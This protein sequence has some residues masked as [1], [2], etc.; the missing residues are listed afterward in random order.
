MFEINDLRA[1]IRIADLKSVSAAAKSLGAP[2]SSVSRSM[3]RLEN[4]A[5]AALVERSTRHLR[6]TDAGNLLYPQALRILESVEVAMSTMVAHAGVPSGVLRINAPS[7]FSRCIIAPMLPSFLKQYPSILVEIVATDERINMLSG[8]F[9]LTIR[10]GAMADSMLVA[11]R[12]RSTELWTC[13]SPSYLAERGTP[14]TLEDLSDHDLI[15]RPDKLLSWLSGDTAFG[16]STTDN[17]GRVRTPGT[18]VVEK[19]LIHH[20]GIGLLP[21]YLAMPAIAHGELVRLFTDQPPLSV[22]VYAV[23]ADHH[24]LSTKV[25]AFIDALLYS[26]EALDAPDV[27]S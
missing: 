7:S 13:A 11:R 21:D 2:K 3:A 8:E 22:E 10:I 16:K 9:D 19:I 5:G 15:G 18:D 4:M 25:R 20:G 1:F 24:S 26:I 27:D 12:I 14:Q 23:Y 17:L 6:L